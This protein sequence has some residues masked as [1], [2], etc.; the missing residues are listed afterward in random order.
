MTSMR[1]DLSPYGTFDLSPDR[2]GN[3]NDEAD[4]NASSPPYPHR[5]RTLDKASLVDSG[6]R[7]PGVRRPRV[8]NLGDAHMTP[9][10]LQRDLN[11]GGFSKTRTRPAGQG[12]GAD[13]GAPQ[14]TAGTRG[15][16]SGGPFPKKVDTAGDSGRR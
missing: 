1:D 8:P 15:G 10:T 4:S 7:A 5:Q 9:G 6:K 2:K 14:A 3:D 12:Q 11:H 13:S 16:S